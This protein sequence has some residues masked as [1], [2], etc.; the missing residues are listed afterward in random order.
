MLFYVLA[1]PTLLR[2]NDLTVFGREEPSEAAA[3]NRIDKW[4]LVERPELR[5]YNYMIVPISC[6]R[7]LYGK[8]GWCEEKIW[9]GGY[10]SIPKELH[11][12]D[13]PK[14]NR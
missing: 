1:I 14:D 8:V 6:V 13:K 4:N 7:R 9:I 10:D 3:K 2:R 5:D 12:L 11:P